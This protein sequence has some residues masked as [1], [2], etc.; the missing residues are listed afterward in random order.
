MALGSRCQ[1]N[2]GKVSFKKVIGSCNIIIQT[3]AYE[4]TYDNKNEPGVLY[5]I[6]I[7]GSFITC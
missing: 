2:L 1:I 6:L 5:F 4:K 7:Y 3:I